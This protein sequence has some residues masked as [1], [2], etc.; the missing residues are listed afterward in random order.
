MH[1]PFLGNRMGK[2]TASPYKQCALNERYWTPRRHRSAA[3]GDVL[4]PECTRASADVSTSV[5]LTIS[6]T[7][8]G[9]EPLPCPFPSLPS[10]S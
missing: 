1:R 9:S 8:V 2:A 4:P 5:S 10:N 7:P 6:S 3:A